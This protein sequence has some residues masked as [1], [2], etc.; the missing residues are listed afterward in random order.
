MKSRNALAAFLLA[1]LPLSG[2]GQSRRAPLS[3]P[4]ILGRLA[5]GQSPSAIAN[6]VKVRGIEFSISDD[7]LSRVKLAGG[8]GILV[9]RLSATGPTQFPASNDGVDGS[10]EHLARCAELLHTGDN[11]KA[12]E[13]CWA[14]MDELPDSPWPVLAMGRAGYGTAI[15][16]EE[17]A[18]LIRRAQALAR[19]PTEA[20]ALLS[21]GVPLKDS[22]AELANPE[23]SDNPAPYYA[24]GT[25]SNRT[26]GGVLMGGNRATVDD[27]PSDKNQFNP[28]LQQM[29]ASDRDLASTHTALADYYQTTGN[30]EKAVSEFQDALRLEPDN[31]ELHGTFA[32]FYGA[33]GDYDEEIA[34]LREAVRIVPYGLEERAELA[35]VLVQQ[36]HADEAIR[37]WREL[38]DLSPGDERACEALGELYI[39]RKDWKSAVAEYKRLLEVRPDSSDIENELAWTYATSPD[40]EYRKPAEALAIAKRAVQTSKE[41]DANF[42]DTLAEALLING[43]AEEALE[44][45]EHAAEL[46]PTDA[47]IQSRLERF[48]QAAEE[49]KSVRQ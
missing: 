6:F 47:N 22:V 10:Y 31:A 19:N 17:M 4:E 25:P 30:L 49:A 20:E 3:R 5:I 35:R 34:E 29:L 33:Q 44:T 45:E 12:R 38:I 46:A 21:G 7:F 27:S 39:Q 48:R 8:D 16:Q 9:E 43:R 28:W 13:E 26:Y 40:P 15:P 18:E 42:I 23:F 37:E 2:F 36:G 32:V 24:L 41:S 11:E 1:L 14:A